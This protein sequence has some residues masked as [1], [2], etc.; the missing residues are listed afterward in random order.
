MSWQLVQ[1]WTGHAVLPDT[2]AM[3]LFQVEILGED[4][5]HIL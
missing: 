4:K 1:L 3:L 2:I 5:G